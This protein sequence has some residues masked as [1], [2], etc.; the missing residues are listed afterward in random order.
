[1]RRLR[2]GRR[3]KVGGLKGIGN[4]IEGPFRDAFN[5][6]ATMWDDTIGKMFHGQFIGAL[7]I[8]FNMPNLQIPHFAQGGIV[9]QP[10]LALIGE[11][12]PEAIVPLSGRGGSSGTGGGGATNNNTYYFQVVSND[13]QS[14][15][16]A[17]RTYIQRNGSLANAGVA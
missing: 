16:N 17:L 9:T 15:V 5:F 6:I 13:P 1:M 11:A 3:T 7:G 12:G 4:D 14:V 10:T 8:G 2:T